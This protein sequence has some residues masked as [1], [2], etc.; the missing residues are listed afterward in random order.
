VKIA[1]VSLV[2][3]PALVGCRVDRVEGRPV[4]RSPSMADIER[5]LDQVLLGEGVTPAIRARRE[6]QRLEDEH[7]RQAGADAEVAATVRE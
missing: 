2:E 3:D 7:R 1:E 4:R 6:Q 5:T